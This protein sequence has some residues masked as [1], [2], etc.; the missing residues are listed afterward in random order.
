MICSDYGEIF[1]GSSVPNGGVIKMVRDLA[2]L[3][4]ASKSYLD[5]LEARGST[6]SYGTPHGGSA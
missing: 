4:K 1:M 2:K 3:Q 5:E 6:C